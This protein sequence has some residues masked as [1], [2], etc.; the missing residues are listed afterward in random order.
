MGGVASDRFSQ[1]K[2]CGA[3]AYRAPAE[4]SRM[5]R[6]TG[7][8]QACSMRANFEESRRQFEVRKAELGP[9]PTVLVDAAEGLTMP[10][11]R[12]MI[13]RQTVLPRQEHIEDALDADGPWD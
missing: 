9:A 5:I 10:S 1:C 7:T 3:R 6:R 11:L 4:V 8:C 12:S 13:L 2:H